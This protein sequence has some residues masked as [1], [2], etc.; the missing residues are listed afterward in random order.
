MARPSEE[1][2]M[3]QIR[4][5]ANGQSFSRSQRI[6]T[7]GK[8]SIDTKTVLQGLRNSMNQAV[9][10]LRKEEP[11]SN[12]SV[13]SVCAFTADHSAVICTVAATRFFGGMA[14]DEDVDI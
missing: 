12:F 13:E 11:G 8:R 1:S 5:L 9:G 6:S 4:S 14:D 2:V 7:V 10:R 3:N